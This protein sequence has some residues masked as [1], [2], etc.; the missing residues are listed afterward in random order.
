MEWHFGWLAPQVPATRENHANGA[1]ASGVAQSTR[2][3]SPRWSSSR[4]LPPRPVTSYFVGADR[5]LG[6][7][8]GLDR[9]QVAVAGRG[10][11]AKEPIVLRS[12]A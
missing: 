10:D 9:Q 12:A 1:G 11:E 8:A 2:A 7:A 4:P 3:N 5:L 6:A